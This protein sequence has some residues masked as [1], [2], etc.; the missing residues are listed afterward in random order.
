MMEVDSVLFRGSLVFQREGAET[1]VDIPV[2]GIL[3][4]T[5]N[6]G[7]QVTLNG[8]TLRGIRF[9][10]ENGEAIVP[11]NDETHCKVIRASLGQL[12]TIVHEDGTVAA[13][14]ERIVTSS[15]QNITLSS[16]NLFVFYAYTMV[17]GAFRWFAPD[18]DAFTPAVAGDWSSAP[19]RISDALDQLA[20][21]S[22]VVASGSAA[23]TS[24]NPLTLW[25][26]SLAE[27][28]V[29]GGRLEITA[30]L[31]DAGATQRSRG[32]I[33]FGASRSV[34][35]SA[36]VT[37]NDSAESGNVPSGVMSIA[38]DGNDALVQVAYMT[39][40]TVYYTIRVECDSLDVPQ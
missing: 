9:L 8:G 10:D 24:G 14:T 28:E 17:A 29:I 16:R 36:A 35:G 26:Y 6:T 39:T 30:G 7:S 2:D 21:R 19:T 20:T 3:V 40:G 18:D 37:N 4:V 13:P 22:P 15:Q 31:V 12:V 11:N 1:P 5:E 38:A 23:I 33:D 25:T 32:F 27:G 34:G